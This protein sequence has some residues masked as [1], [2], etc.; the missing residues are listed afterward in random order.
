MNILMKLLAE[1]SGTALTLIAQQK[2]IVLDA[3][4]L[5]R[6]CPLLQTAVQQEYQEI[7]SQAEGLA[8]LGNAWIKEALNV[9]CNHAALMALQR[10]DLLPA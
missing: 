10:G 8:L 4:T 2:G 9:A 1:G 3:P 7:V 5:D 6:L